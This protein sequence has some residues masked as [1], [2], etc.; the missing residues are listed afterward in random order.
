[1]LCAGFE[2]PKDMHRR[3]AGMCLRK[4]AECG[5]MSGLLQIRKSSAAH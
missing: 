5:S 2:Q 3:A 1:M 4:A